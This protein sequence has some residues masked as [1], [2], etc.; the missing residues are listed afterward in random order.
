M[1]KIRIF[2]FKNLRNGEHF[3]YHWSI[4]T[5]LKELLRPSLG[6]VSL[7]NDY[8]SI[9]QIEYIVYKQN[10]KAEETKEIKEADEKRDAAFRM[11]KL[12][13][14]AAALSEEAEIQTAGKK[15]KLVF[16][17]YKNA[18]LKPYLENTALVTNLVQ[19]LKETQHA[20]YVEQ[21]NLTT[22][23][24]S[25]SAK[26]EAFETI[27]NERSIEKHEKELLGTMVEIRP[28]VD[29]TYRALM[30]G[31]QALY[32]SNELVGKNAELHTLLTSIIDTI[33]SYIEQM[34]YVYKRRA[35]RKN[36]K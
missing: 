20:V 13:I 10:P 12:S 21:L 11:L 5:F 24:E 8:E 4:I 22:A 6:L 2:Y 1:K 35:G 25:L 34:Q 19:D 27:Y 9:F 16:E 33:N 3:Q 30:D 18:Y 28:Q 23:V 15:L 36:G 14:D 17:N 31:I 29:K 26:N 32:A 7:W